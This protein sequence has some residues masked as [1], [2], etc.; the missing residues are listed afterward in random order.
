M[1]KEEYIITPQGSLG[2]LALGH[3]GIQKWRDVVKAEKEKKE[4]LK[5]STKNVEKK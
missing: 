4:L 5:E 1:E 2:L 3:I